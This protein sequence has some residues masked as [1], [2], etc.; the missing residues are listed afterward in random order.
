M[1]ASAGILVNIAFA[2]PSL[3][4]I[5][6]TIPES[7]GKMETELSVVMVMMKNCSFLIAE[8]DQMKM[9]MR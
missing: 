3:I 5:M 1:A 2:I 8:H 6:L 9:D 7:E 4:F